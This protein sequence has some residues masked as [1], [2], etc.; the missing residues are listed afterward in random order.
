[1]TFGVRNDNYLKV[2]GF[3]DGRE[4]LQV[5]VNK[6]WHRGSGQVMSCHLF[7]ELKSVGANYVS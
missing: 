4:C 2:R 5:Q 7:V 6:L 3:K 1:M